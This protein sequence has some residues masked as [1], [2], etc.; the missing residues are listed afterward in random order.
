MAKDRQNGVSLTNWPKS[1]KMAKDRQNGIRLTIWRK[2][3]RLAY[4]RQ[5]GVDL[6]EWRKSTP[7]PGLENKSSV[8]RHSFALLSDEHGVL[9]E[10]LAIAFELNIIF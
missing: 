6:T 1:A 5:T 10:K 7:V 4:V 3:D 2:S 9:S 8:T